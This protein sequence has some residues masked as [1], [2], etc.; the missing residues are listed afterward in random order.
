[1]SARN[2]LCSVRGAAAAEM[3]LILPLLFILLFGGF[4]AGHYV[5][6]HH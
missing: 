2:F 1:M 4:E 3:A 5:W 6:S